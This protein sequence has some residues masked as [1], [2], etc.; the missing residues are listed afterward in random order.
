MDM[1]KYL[2]EEANG[3]VTP[4]S[5]FGSRGEGHIRQAYAQLWEDIREG[6]GRIGEALA[7]L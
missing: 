7:R 2:R 5:L 3:V 6:L 1:A 4:G